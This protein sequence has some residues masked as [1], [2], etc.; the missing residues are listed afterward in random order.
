MNIKKSII[1]TATALVFL[2]SSAI[3]QPQQVTIP[4]P[5]SMSQAPAARAV[6]AP[7]TPAPTPVTPVTVAPAPEEPK[8]PT[9]EIQESV[10]NAVNNSMPNGAET[11]VQPNADGMMPVAT[12]VVE[13]SVLDATF[14]DKL[15]AAI[16][17]KNFD[18][19]YSNFAKDGFVVITPMGDGL[20]TQDSFKDK[21]TMLYGETGLMKDG[22][23]AMS[24]DSITNL[25]PTLGFVT[26]KVVATFPQDP[27]KKV[28]GMFSSLVKKEGNDW[29]IMSLHISSKDIVQMMMEK[30]EAPKPVVQEANLMEKIQLPLIGLIIGFVLA[31]GI[32]KVR[33]RNQ[34]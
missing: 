34:E 33:N 17:T 6:Q 7:V 28:E 4:S 22:V 25:T 32:L 20:A 16:N 21:F 3:A 30:V 19:I 31:F 18:T 11:Y 14:I 2:C 1:L 13:E 24:A 23:I 15:S 29:F 9:V 26:A 12:P 27:S 10:N 8:T 5:D